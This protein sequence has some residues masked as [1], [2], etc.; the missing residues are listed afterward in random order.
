M[1]GETELRR[2]SYASNEISG[3]SDSN[4]EDAVEDFV[5]TH[6]ATVKVPGVGA[7]TLDSTA[8]DKDEIDLKLD[9]GSGRAMEGK[10]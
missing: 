6:D 3:R 5:K 8:L 7:I 4:M 1:S 10:I 2:N 9:F